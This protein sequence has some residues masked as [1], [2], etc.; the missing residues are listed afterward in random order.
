MLGI[1]Y[2]SRDQGH[3]SPSIAPSWDQN[4]INLLNNMLDDE[5]LFPCQSFIFE[6]FV[7]EAKPTLEH[8]WQEA[9][10]VFFGVQ[11]GKTCKMFVEE[12]ATTFPQEK[13]WQTE[14]GL[15]R[16]A[17]PIRPAVQYGFMPLATYPRDTALLAL[18]HDQA[19]CTNNRHAY[20]T[21]ANS[22]LIAFE[23]GTLPVTPAVTYMRNYMAAHRDVWNYNAT[24]ER[25]LSGYSAQSA[26]EDV[27]LAKESLNIQLQTNSMLNFINEII[28]V[29][30]CHH[31]I[32]IH[33]TM[34]AL[35][36]QKHVYYTPKWLAAM[37]ENR[38]IIFKNRLETYHQQ[39]VNIRK[40]LL[41]ELG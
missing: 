22:L 4:Y 8:A 27:E 6:S 11:Q 29:T 26:P 31:N 17:L 41:I 38:Q 23:A 2:F 7:R 32:D 13:H 20:S 30:S 5:V 3:S 10:K 19:I 28:D 14:L 33:L 35:F 1:S 34:F 16:F 18:C 40:A 25:L 21:Y 15:D 39:A 12:G 37:R 36:C 9:N 24:K